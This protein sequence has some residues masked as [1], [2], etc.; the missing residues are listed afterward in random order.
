M[1][2][3]DFASHEPRGITEIKVSLELISIVAILMLSF[4]INRILYKNYYIWLNF[5]GKELDK[6]ADWHLEMWER[7]I[8][9]Y[10]GTLLWH[11]LKIAAK[12][13]EAKNGGK[14]LPNWR[15]VWIQSPR[16]S[17]KAGLNWVGVLQGDSTKD[18]WPMLVLIL[19]NREKLGE[20]LK[21]K[22][23]LDK[24]KNWSGF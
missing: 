22:A 15:L 7:E 2:V 23:T 17:L 1:S 9:C 18:N 20:D 16:L 11:Y 10:L 12:L 3:K 6:E 19:K 24:N 5:K 13:Q 21:A 14:P 4:Q 8:C